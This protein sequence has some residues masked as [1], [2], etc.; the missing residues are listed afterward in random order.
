MIVKMQLT[1][2]EEAMKRRFPEP[3]ALIVSKDKKGRVN[4]CPIGYFTLVT[5]EP[6]VWAIALYYSHFSTKVISDTREFVLC[7]PSME[8]AKDVLYCGSVHGW[9][10][11]KT[12]HTNFTF[13]SALKINPPI[14]E[15]CVACFECRVLEKHTIKDHMLFLGEVVASYQSERDWQEKI[16][17]WDDRHLGTIKLGGKSAKISYSPEG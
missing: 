4:L 2:T 16:Y 3:V 9:K 14:I 11:D 13:K 12:K 5:W 17:N 15:D 1:D 7:L 10:I 8:Q 6:K